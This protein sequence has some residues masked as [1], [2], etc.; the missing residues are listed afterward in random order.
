MSASITP[1]TLSISQSELDELHRRL[2]ATRWPE[3]ETVSDWS[4]GAPLDEVR[5]LVDYWRDHYD[6]RRCEARLNTLGQHVTVIDGLAIHL[7]HVRSPHADAIPLLLTHG[8]PGS[9]VEFIEIIGPLTDPMAHGGR[10]EDA[11]HLVMPSLPG[12]GF[13]EK[14]A[15]TGWGVEKIA[16]AWIELMG[17]LG[18]ARWVA[19]GGDWGSAVTAEI[20]VLAPPGCM[21][22]HVN[23]A[24][25]PSLPEDRIDPTPAEQAAFERQHYFERWDSGYAVEQRTRPQTIGYS[26]V[27]SPVG[28]AAWIFEKMF[29]WT[30]NA[31]SPFDAL[32]HD[33]ILDNIMIY[34]L[35]ASGASAARL[36]WESAGRRRTGEVAIP[37]GST[38]FPKE[39]IPAPRKWVER[40]MTQLV[41]WNQV[42]KGGHFPA[43]EQPALFAEELRASFSRM[44]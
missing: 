35:T 20:G 7:L 23:M 44:R 4:Q 42:A 15:A 13:S 5:S 25:W 41:Y 24:S 22:V 27:D 9:I 43:W 10:V 30:D 29:A 40:R 39:I 38:A 19:Q 18:Y 37:S 14:P 6:W 8:W 34:W 26:L 2:V 28:L 1:F 33:T 3:R 16:G 32:S 21:G 11:F 17:R 31:G 36:Y 12:Y